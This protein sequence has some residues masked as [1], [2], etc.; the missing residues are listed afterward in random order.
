RP[1]AGPLVRQI[2]TR[3]TRQRLPV[4]TWL[5]CRRPAAPSQAPAGTPP[6]AVLERAAYGVRHAATAGPGRA[7]LPARAPLVSVPDDRVL[8]DRGGDVRHGEV[9]RRGEHAHAPA[10]LAQAGE[11]F[12]D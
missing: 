2:P 8:G 7:A 12:D 9:L 1:S 3:P 4:A 6:T 11:V 5:R 10:R